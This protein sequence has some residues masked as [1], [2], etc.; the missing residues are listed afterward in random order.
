[1]RVAIL[2]ATGTARKRTIPA[3]R[4]QNLCEIVA[5][6]GRDKSKIESLA[7]EYSI[8]RTFL[9]SIDLL[10]VTQ[11]DFVFIGSPP[12]FHH[13]QIRQCLQRGVP[14]L[15]EKPLCLSSSEAAAIQSFAVT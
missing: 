2:S 15:C 12:T 13:D 9:S 4:E 8:P 7:K 11:P 10:D 6:H 1:M 5:I 3:I 14:V